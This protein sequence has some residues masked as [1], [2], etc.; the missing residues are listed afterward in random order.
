M[1]TRRD[2]HSVDPTAHQAGFTIE[3]DGHTRDRGL[4]LF[5]GEHRKESS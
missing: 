4:R 5:E 1:T 3:D 2:I